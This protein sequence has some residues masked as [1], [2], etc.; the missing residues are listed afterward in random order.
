MNRLRAFAALAFVAS[1][2][3]CSGGAGVTPSANSNP[4][5]ND[6]A[7]SSINNDRHVSVATAQRIASGTSD[8]DRYIDVDP[9]SLTFRTPATRQ[10]KVSTKYPTIVFA[11]SSNPDV[12]RVSPFYRVI[13]GATGGTVYFTATPVTNGKAK[14]GVIDTLLAGDRI[15]VTV[16]F[17][18][19]T[20]A[21]TATPTVKPTVKPTATPTATPTAKPTATPSATPTPAGCPA[22]PPDPVTASL[23]LSG[24]VQ[25][26]TLPCYKDAKIVA[27]IP[28]NNSTAAN[29]I[30]VAVAVSELNK[31]GAVI[32]ATKGTP[33]G[34]TS[35]SPNQTVN[36]TPSSA[37]IAT[38][39]TSPSLVTPGHTYAFTVEVKEFNYAVIQSGTATQSGDTLSFGVA[40]PGGSFNGGLHAIVIIYKK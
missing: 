16:A 35:L 4:A 14:I 10:I 38:Q 29:P 33:I 39:F 11:A 22:P 21:P 37:V 30:T 18:S 17:G 26:V 7:A 40:P 6:R 2:A 12:V 20:P 24:S 13:P 25:T 31:F 32:D 27:T 28:A 23:L 9:D 19:G 34:F 1:L 8:P 15:P 36:F 5:A 3:A